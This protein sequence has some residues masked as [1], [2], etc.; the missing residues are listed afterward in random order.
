M[1]L[2]PNFVVQDVDNIQF[3]IPLGSESFRGLVRSNRTAAFIVNCLREETT[4]EKIVDAM[5]ET[6]DAP[7]E[8]IAADVAEILGMLREI[9]AVEE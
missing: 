7:R 3:L 2:K 8:T 6:Y 5:C 1:K 9:N 4:E